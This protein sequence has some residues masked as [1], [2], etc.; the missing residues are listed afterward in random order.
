MAETSVNVPTDPRASYFIVSKTKLANGNLQ[1]VSRRVGPS[2]TSYSRRE[3]NCGGMRFRYTGEG[4]TLSE[5]NQ[6]YS[7]GAMGPLTEGSISTYI[8]L[9]ACRGR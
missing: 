9:A 2:G 4:D 6:P 5:I 7:K 3:I 1:V 8:A